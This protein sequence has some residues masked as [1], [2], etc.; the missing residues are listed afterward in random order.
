MAEQT[1]SLAAA[2]AFP[3]PEAI[4]VWWGRCLRGSE[5]RCHLW[6]PAGLC[7]L[8]GLAPAGLSEQLG[9]LFLVSTSTEGKT[10]LV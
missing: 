8:R 10:S 9:I 3:L 1:K 4:Q 5:G 7:L 6:S 2:V